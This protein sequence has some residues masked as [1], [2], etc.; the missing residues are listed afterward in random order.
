MTGSAGTAKDVIIYAIAFNKR[1]VWGEGGS[2]WRQVLDLDDLFGGSK[3]D[4]EL[5]TFI[6]SFG[7]A[8]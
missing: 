2:R 3:T 1:G 5:G 4:H 8:F 6:F 7:S